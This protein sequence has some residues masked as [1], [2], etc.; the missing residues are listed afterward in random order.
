M[1]RNAAGQLV[2]AL[3]R[4]T[5]ATP[6]GITTGATMLVTKDGGTPTTGAGTLTYIGSGTA[7]NGTAGL[8]K[9]APTAAET[10]A[11]HVSFMF[12]SSNTNTVMQNVQFEPTSG[13]IL[14]QASLSATGGSVTNQTTI[15]LPSATPIPAADDDAYNNCEIVFYDSSTSGQVSV[16][17][18]L[19]YVGSTRTI[20]LR[21]APTFTITASDYVTIIANQ[22]LQSA[23]KD[24]RLVVDSDGLGDANAVKV[25]PSGSGTAQT[26]RDIGAAV[27]AAAAG[28]SGGLLISGSNTGTTTFGA[29][30]VTNATTLS[31]AV[32]LGS[33]LVVTGNTTFTGSITATNGSNSISGVTATLSTAESRSVISGTS[34]TNTTTTVVFNDST[35]TASNYYQGMLVKFTSGN[36]NGQ[37]RVVTS[38]SN[39]TN[40]TT[41]TVSRAF[42]TTPTASA[43]YTV[44]SDDAAKV[45][46]SSRVT[47]DLDTIKTQ[48]ITCSAGVTVAAFVGNATAALSVDASGRVDVGKTLGS[49]VTLDANNVLNVSAK[50]WAGT[51]ITA[52][53]I[54]VATAAGLSGGLFIAGS[55]AATTV[56]ITGNLTGNV[57]GSVG[58]VTGLTTATIATAVW[59]DTTAGDF[60]TST[61]PGKIIFSQLGGAFTTTSSSVFSTAALANGPSG[62]SAPTA[63]QIA[64]AVWTDTTASDFTTA[65]SIGKSIMNGVSLGTGLTVANLT[66]APTSGDLTAAMIASVTAACTASTPAAT[67]GSLGADAIT[68]TSLATSAI[69]KIQANMATT[70]NITALNNISTTDVKNQVIA[71]LDT[72]TYTM[73]GAETP[74]ETTTLRKMIQFLY[75]WLIR[76]KTQTST[77]TSLYSADGNTVEQKAPVSDDGTTTTVGKIVTGP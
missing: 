74:A 39:T 13:P 16:G 71:A 51:A 46:S 55:N 72:D 29:L 14:Y 33:T 20:T 57:S 64:T 3:L 38:S 19:D 59:T 43:T 27:P 53:S 6:T 24:R 68:G 4:T 7:Y 35:N 56:N 75:K 73:P 32:Q 50:Y 54:P 40:V 62:G 8:W 22:S 36:C 18:V 21:E 70:E 2:T 12:G 77:F 28:A 10:N 17:V 26:A 60:T 45:D 48:S 69:T 30:T 23:T 15:V 47:A 44:L 37:S 66:N 1:R 41:L 31:G 5:S 76:K 65:N 58:S 9:Y 11:S 52:T 61:S 25:G 49:A 63:A 67:I 42:T 34:N